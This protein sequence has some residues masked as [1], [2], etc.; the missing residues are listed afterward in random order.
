MARIGIDARLTYYT[1]GGISQYTQHLLRELPEL[2]RHHTFQVL[3]SWKDERDLAK[4]TMR[5]VS[6]WTPSHHRFERLALALE[7][8]PRRLDLLHSPDFIPPLFGA[9]KYVITIHDL[10]FLH[11]P[12][13]LT[14]ESRRYY[15]GQIAAA[16]QRADRII[17]VSEATRRD[18]IDLLEVAPEKLDVVLEGVTANFR[19]LPPG[20]LIPALEKYRL[21]AGY[22]LFVSTLEPRKNVSGLLR[23]YAALRAILPDTP[24]LV[25]VG[26]QGWLPEPVY[27]MAEKLNLGDH[28][29]WLGRVS[30]EML[31]ALYG[32]AGVFCLPSFYEGFGLPPLEAMAC[33]TPVIVSQRASLPEVVGEAGLLINPDDTDDLAEA[34]RRVVTDSTLAADMRKNGLTQAGKFSWRRAAQETLAVYERTLAE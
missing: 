2:A 23:A 18:V 22:I 8:A 13:F 11:Y 5:R 27:G 33:G 25:L 26:D 20:D 28:V 9:G 17:S 24:P 32:A 6:C 31:P 29:R 16:V 14:A 1:Q 34:L 21:T 3:H 4:S 19:P 30:Y 15:N 12:Q 10:A 7:V